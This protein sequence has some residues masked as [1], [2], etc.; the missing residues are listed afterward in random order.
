MEIVA[1]VNNPEGVA[2]YLRHIGLSDHPPPI[3]PAQH[4]QL[5]FED[6]QTQPSYE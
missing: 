4:E 3:Q 2:R 6:V 5:T 1:D